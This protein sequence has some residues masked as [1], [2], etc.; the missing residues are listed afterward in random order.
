M[1]GDDEFSVDEEDL[2][3]FGVLS[4]GNS[5]D[6]KT[7]DTDGSFQLDSTN[8]GVPIV[9]AYDVNNDDPEN[10]TGTTDFTAP[11]TDGKV[12]HPNA[13]DNN[14]FQNPSEEGPKETYVHLSLTGG[15]LAA[16]D[17][18]TAQTKA[19]N[20]NVIISDTVEDSF[21]VTVMNRTESGTASGSGE[22]I[23]EAD[24]N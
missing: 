19:R 7:N 2:T 6:D 24:S 8:R 22:G 1:I 9:L 15:V 23:I 5:G 16:D 10:S 20:S 21:K 14:K 17:V 11:Y 13:F 4:L 18:T 12:I 3:Q